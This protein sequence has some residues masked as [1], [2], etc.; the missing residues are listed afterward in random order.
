MQHSVKCDMCNKIFLLTKE[1]LRQV[2]KTVG[3]TSVECT[4]FRCKHCNHAYPVLW[5]DDKMRKLQSQYN[6]ERIKVN[7]ILTSG[8]Q[9][10]PQVMDRLRMLF[11][12]LTNRSKLLNEFYNKGLPMFDKLDVT[13]TDS[14]KEKE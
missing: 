10:T 2:T 8:R 12:S 4:F 7:K 5:V 13:A 9:V 11:D 3:S 6:K 1:D 14:G